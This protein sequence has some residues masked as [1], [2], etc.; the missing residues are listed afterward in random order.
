MNPEAAHFNFKNSL[1]VVIPSLGGSCLNKTIE[2][3]N[4]G[5]FIPDEILVSLPSKEHIDKIKLKENNVKLINANCYGQ[6]SQR[7][8]GFKRAKHPFVLQLDDD[9]I[10]DKECISLLID[11]VKN[12][13]NIVASPY[14]L[15]FENNP[16]HKAGPA[17]LLMNFFHLLMNGINGFQ[18]GK[19]AISGINYGV[20]KADINQQHG[21]FFVDW[22]P[23]GCLMHNNKN[24]IKENYFP[25]TGK[26]YSEDLIHSFLLKNNN[27]KLVTCLDAYC[28]IEK[29]IEPHTIKDIIKDFK[30]RKHFVEMASLGKTRMYVF[31]WFVFLKFIYY[32]ARLIARSA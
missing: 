22:Q 6:V 32:K 11:C 8:F 21:N 28:Y 4:S 13:D 19:I 26:A 27:L 7:V 17:T 3:L 24:L 29:D 1:S 15:D 2:S 20:N 10:I 31:Y 16:I 5:N 23:G 18:T 9:V 25:F 12:S 14:Y 30:A